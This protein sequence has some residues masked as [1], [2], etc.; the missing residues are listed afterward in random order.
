MTDYPESLARGWVRGFSNS[1]KSK[2][3][4]DD[5]ASSQQ[6]ILEETFIEQVECEDELTRLMHDIASKFATI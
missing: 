2:H 5:Q 1:L 3:S 4:K 6:H